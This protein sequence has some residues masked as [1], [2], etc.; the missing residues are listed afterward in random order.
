MNNKQRT[1][2]IDLL[3]C[4]VLRQVVWHFVSERFWRTS[5]EKILVCT[6][7]S[8][9]GVSF[10][11]SCYWEQEKRFCS[12]FR[13]LHKEGL[14]E[15]HTNLSKPSIIYSHSPK[16]TSTKN[17]HAAST[18]IKYK[19][20]DC[21]LVYYGETG[22]SLKR[23]IGSRTQ[24]CSDIVRPEIESSTTREH[25]KPLLWF[26]ECLHS[27][28]RTELPQKNLFRVVVLGGRQELREW[29]QRHSRNLRVS[30]EPFK[31]LLI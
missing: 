28:Q 1:A 21:D 29:P 13:V 4:S 27:Y 5:R 3:L 15:L 8:D 17:K 26:W 6:F 11:S 19:C 7:W 31:Q 30:L 9:F 12:F 23:R 22:K 20:K 2:W 25:T 18:C 14:E 24:R 10:Q 16:T